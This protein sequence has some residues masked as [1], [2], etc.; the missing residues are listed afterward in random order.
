V[1]R[2][3]S[4]HPLLLLLL[5][6]LWRSRTLA[7]APAVASWCTPAGTVLPLP[8]CHATTRKPALHAAATTAPVPASLCL[9]LLLL[10]LVRPAEL[11]LLAV[12][13][14]SSA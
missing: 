11:L 5:V 8:L 6:V 9:L 14:S 4:K 13:W 10:L 3:A 7:P 2:N 1:S 12:L